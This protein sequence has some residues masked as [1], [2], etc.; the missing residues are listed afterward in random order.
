MNTIVQ[1]MDEEELGF[2]VAE[3]EGLILLPL[4]ISFSL[5]LCGKC[6]SLHWGL[7]PQWDTMGCH[8]RVIKWIKG[9]HDAS[10]SEHATSG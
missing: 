9:A 5:A 8:G 3:V 6:V 10:G 2:G 7:L 1:R 4:L